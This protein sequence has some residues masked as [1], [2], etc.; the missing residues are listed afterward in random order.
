[1]R[2]SMRFFALPLLL[3]GLLGLALP[4]AAQ[5]ITAG[6]FGQYSSG[7]YIFADE[8]E[9][10]GWTNSLTVEQGRVQVGLSVPILIQT[11]PWITTTGAGLTPS[12]GPQH[13]SVDRNQRGSRR[14]RNTSIALPDTTGARSTGVGDPSVRVSVDVVRPSLSGYAV[15]VT[16]TLKPPLANADAGFSTGAWDGGLGLSVARSFDAWFVIVEG[17][18]WWLGDLDDLPLRETLSYS[19][20]VGQTL[21][22]GRWGVLASVAGSTAVIEDVTPPVSITGGLSYVRPGWGLNTTVGS[23]LTEGAADW[24]VGLGG[25]VTVWD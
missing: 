9:V 19:L 12:G 6:T 20:A 18:V 10:F 24:S 11:T 4:A 21:F 2:F 22:D 23:G 17:T 5:T 8:T 14:G 13:E 7:D 1:M 3:C 16:G 15:Q 25:H